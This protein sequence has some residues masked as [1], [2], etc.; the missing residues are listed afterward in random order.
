VAE[1]F[2]IALREGFEAALI[3]AIV[4]AF[5]RRRA[6]EK[7]G[8]VWLG[9]GIAL[10]VSVVVGLVLHVTVDGLEGEARMRTFAAICLAAAVLLTWM[11][12]WM[13]KHA[14][15]LKGELEGKAGAAIADGSTMALAFVAF[16]A[17]A[18]EGLETALFL[19]ST[20]T[21]SDGG[22]VVL[23]TLLGLVLATVLG[24][25]VYQGS[26]LIDMRKF[27]LV[28]GLL[29]I[30]FAAGLLAR[31]VLFLQASGDLGTWDN[32]V[33]NLTGYDWLTQST[34]SGRFLAGIFGWDPRP[35]IEQVIAYLGFLLPVG[36]L[37]FRGSKPAPAS[38]PASSAAA[39]STAAASSASMPSGVASS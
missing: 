17:V 6:P 30:L 29:I 35:S 38:A 21:S 27:F 25:L 1:S 22:D 13:R 36:F 24:F 23:G 33:Y 16:T 2:L 7:A 19:L 12:F 4:L 15:S 5:V 31:A 37:Y 9:T 8:A 18:R 28:T 14:R 32:A 39:S 11:I 26:H 3:V 34:Q 20:T 10:G